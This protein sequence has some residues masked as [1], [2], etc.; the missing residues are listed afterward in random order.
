MPDAV[1]T[2]AIIPKGMNK[3]S[4]WH[5]V[6]AP[7]TLVSFSMT[8]PLGGGEGLGSDVGG[9]SPDQHPSCNYLVPKTPGGG[10]RGPEGLSPSCLYKLIQVADQM[11]ACLPIESGTKLG[12]PINL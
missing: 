8:S 9:A 3:Q 4:I 6:G 7:Q 12:V 2:C 1:Y 10:L 5:V 11:K